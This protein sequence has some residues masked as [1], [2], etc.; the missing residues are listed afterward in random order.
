MGIKDL[1]PFLK[2]VSPDLIREVQLSNFSGKRVAIDTSIYLYKFLYK[3]D[4]FIESF[5]KQI[6]RL[7]VNNITPIYIFDGKPPAEKMGE[8][9]SRQ[10]K[11]MYYMEKIM[12]LNNQINEINENPVVQDQETIINTIDTEQSNIEGSEPVNIVVSKKDLQEQ[13]EKF[14]KKL[15]IVTKEHVRAL[16]YFFDL[17]NI[18]YIQAN[19]EADIICSKLCENGKVDMVLSDDMDLLASGSKLVLRNFNVNSNKITVYNVDNILQILDINYNQWI[20]FCILCG[21][22]YLKRVRG[23]GPKNAYSCIKIYGSIEKI[24][25]NMFGE[26]KKFTLP[27]NYDYENA[28]KLFKECDY[29]KDEY[30]KMDVCIEPLFDNQLDEIRKYLMKHTK[31]TDKTISNRLK[32]IY[33]L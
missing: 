12:E 1:N 4:R 19:C 2:A 11:K 9:K 13:L 18:K 21:C 10:D 24:I 7:R 16:K 32:T 25:E 28:R 5:F 20:D 33:N 22:D 3:N 15:I 29:Y 27:E 8:I 17:L 6:N 14:E 31:L 26:G 30:N 23:M